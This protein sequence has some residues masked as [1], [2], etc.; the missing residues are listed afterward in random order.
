V[1][2]FLASWRPS[3]GVSQAEAHILAF[4]SLAGPSPIGAVHQAFAHKRSTL[5]GVLDRLET[6]GWISREAH[7][8]DRRSI[9]L[10]LTPKGVRQASRVRNAMEALSRTLSNE[11]S[12][13][14]LAAAARCLKTLEHVAEHIA[15]SADN[16]D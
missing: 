14:A 10:R 16:G 9:L 13:H 8:G 15:K 2:L 1:E 11:M 4:L 7:P 3:L 12:P 5:T 6:K